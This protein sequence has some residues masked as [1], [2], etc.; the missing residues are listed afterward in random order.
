MST[1]AIADFESQY[2]QTWTEPNSQVRRG[3][4]DRMWTTNGR[5]IVSSL[6]VTVEGIEEIAAHITRVHE[7]NIVGKGL[8]F[9]YDQHLQA[10]DALLLRWSMLAP[11]G[12]SIGRGVDV[13]FR[14][15]EGR[16]ETVYMFMG[17][18]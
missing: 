17:V 18:N 13:I 1:D 2:L 10:G 5:M 12:D 7:D 3:H 6:G 8:R 4:I 9:T 15:P 14:D 16:V 11:S